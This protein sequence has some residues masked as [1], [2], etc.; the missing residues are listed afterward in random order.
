[1]TSRRSITSKL[2]RTKVACRRCRKFGSASWQ[3]SG[4]WKSDINN[5]AYLQFFCHWGRETYDYASQALKKIGAHEMA[6]LIDRCQAIVDEH[7][8]SESSSHE[9]M[10]RLM[11]N[12]V[13]GCDGELVKEAGSILPDSVVERIY[14]LS[15]E[16]MDY[17]DDLA[18]LG[19]KY[20]SPYIEG[21]AAGGSK[22][23]T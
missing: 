18:T 8:I 4:D 15:Y 6:E 12:P 20:Y 1:M 21:D 13:I 16:F 10:L 5:G 11:P 23:C 9:H 17:P 3:Q 14:E 19:L 2:S 7:F 22:R